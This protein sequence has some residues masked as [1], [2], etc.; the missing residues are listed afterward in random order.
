[1]R[2]A[3]EARFYA[4]TTAT[5]C[6]LALIA[7]VVGA[8]VRA[9]IQDLVFDQYQRWHP[10]PYAFDQP[11][12]VVDVDEES[13]KRVG[14]WPWP[15]DRLAA[16]VQALKGAGAAAIAFDVLFSEKDRADAGAP[17]GETPDDVFARAIDGA[18][19]VLGSFV[20]DAPNG[21]ADPAKA[22]FVT[23]GDDATKFLTPSPGALAPLSALAQHAAGV[24]FLNWR[25]DSD[26]VVRRVPLILN[27][28]G[29]LR[30]SLA[31]EAL[32]VAQGASTYIVKS[33]N[34]SGET[35]FGEVYGVL[36]VRNGDLTIDTD[37][38]GD[39][40]PYFARSDPRRSISAWKVLTPGADLSE[41]RGAIVFVGASAVTLSDIV[42]TPSSP[43]VPGVEAHAQIL[44]QILS[45]VT[46]R[47]PDWAPS[48]EWMATALLCAALV[49]TT[50]VLAPQFAALVFAA[51]V[52]AVVAVSLFA[53][54]RHGL[55]IDP[56]YPAFSA[57]AVYF[58]GVSTLYAVK[59]HQEREIRS[60]FGRFVSPAVV[61]RLAEMPGALELGGLQRQLTLL[62]CDIRSFTTISEGFNASELT[63]FLNQ[64]L[65]PMTD[66]ILDAAGTVDKYMGDAIV[67]FWN[68]PLDDPDH[69]RHAVEAALAMRRTLVTLN[70]GW[71]RRAEAEERSFKPVRF[72]IG[73]NSGECCVG[74]LG[75]LRRFDYSAIGDEV[76]VASRLE[77]A[78]K[79]FE[80]DI[81]GSETT[82][83]E[84]PD[85]AWLEIDSVLVKGKT[86]P[87]GLYALG[88]D[89]ALAQSEEFSHLSRMHSAMLAAY[90]SRD[91]RSAATMA[92]EAAARAPAAV[93]GLY[94]YNLR[95]FSQLAENALDPDWRPLIA[96][97][98]K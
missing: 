64:Y 51:A 61:A 7:G 15:R 76:N 17:A 58:T 20:S 89:V 1:M 38:A 6:A 29:S 37:A 59:R 92:K 60:A 42:A 84:A 8:P 33:S 41:L 80:V 5:A 39:I 14:Q 66:A 43:E 34:A 70:D 94:S 52:G 98:E 93:R 86:R 81:I 40:R 68:A 88:G 56:T 21:A 44:E 16:L 53:F 82:R 13:L 62:F 50:W 78:C 10:R 75:S 19:V 85:F 32:R 25:P 73:L 54:S 23:A 35:A 71:R 36:A 24:G 47:R 46:L 27:V 12:R 28:D 2:K 3:S 79:I 18:P 67:A 90:R 97:D 26:R 31:M 69:G 4:M 63:H 55:L 87:V 83:A 11:V 77:G 96:L 74:N 45:G 9:V 30:P 49:A 48:G 57:A 65:T 95:R 72:G 91:F 22:G